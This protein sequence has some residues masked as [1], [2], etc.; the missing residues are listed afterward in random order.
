MRVVGESCPHNKTEKNILSELHKNITL[1]QTSDIFAKTQWILDKISRHRF[2]YFVKFLIMNNKHHKYKIFGI[3]YWQLVYCTC[4]VCHASCMYNVL[5]LSTPHFQN[6]YVIWNVNE[7]T[8][9]DIS[10]AIDKSE[11][12]CRQNSHFIKLWYLN[13]KG[14]D[15]DRTLHLQGRNW[16]ADFSW[17]SWSN[18]VLWLVS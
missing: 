11:T 1:I 7:W 13:W 6:V 17:Y 3:K 15:R 8:V 9:I 14:V 5:S 10:L 18:T 2:G 16:T 4:W 12:N